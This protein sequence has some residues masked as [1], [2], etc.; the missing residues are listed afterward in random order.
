MGVW[1]EKLE[2]FSEDTWQERRLGLGRES[3]VSSAARGWPASWPVKT[4]HRTQQR[5]GTQTQL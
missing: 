2:K 1:G 3:A 4:S 5:K